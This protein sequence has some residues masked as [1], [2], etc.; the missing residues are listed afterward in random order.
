MDKILRFS[1]SEKVFQCPICKSDLRL[2]HSVNLI[3]TSNL[4]IT[5]ICYE[6][7][8]ENLSWFYKQFVK[9]FGLT[10]VEYRKKYE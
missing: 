9:K 2:E 1:G 8:F 6:C 10:P 4:S 5:E 7:G 3:L